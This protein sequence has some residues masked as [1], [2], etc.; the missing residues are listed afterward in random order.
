MKLKELCGGHILSGVETGTKKRS[1]VIWVNYIKFCLDGTVYVAVEDPDDGYRSTCEELEV[2]ANGVCNIKIPDTYVT[3]S[4][5]PDGTSSNDVLII[6]DVATGKP[7]LEVGTENYVDYYPCCVMR[8][9]PENLVW[10][11][12][13]NQEKKKD[14]KH[15]LPHVGYTPIEDR[16]Q[17]FV[18]E[19]KYESPITVAAEQ[20]KVAFE[21]S[22]MEAIQSFG[23]NVDLD[24]LTKALAYDRGQYEQGWL[25]GLTWMRN[26]M[27]KAAQEIGQQLL[28]NTARVGADSLLTCGKAIGITSYL[29]ALRKFYEEEEE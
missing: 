18:E 21:G 12:E 15:P 8:W 24:E 10:N 17:T 16:K 28:E 1:Q 23:I 2:E 6:T 26:R 13:W 5:A 29:D 25:D 9:M 27:R 4:M 19:A 20:M 11:Q 3:C 14:C 22:V 7:V